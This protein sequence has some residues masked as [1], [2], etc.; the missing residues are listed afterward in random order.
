M[1]D[2]RLEYLG[3]PAETPSTGEPLGGLELEA[4]VVRF[5]RCQAAP[6]AQ[7]D[8]SEEPEAAEGPE[9]PQAPADL[10]E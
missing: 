4:E 9:V 6:E 1:K 3:A 7:V 8:A 5:R 10:A 2:L